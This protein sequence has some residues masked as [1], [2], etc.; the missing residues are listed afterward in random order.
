LGIS[1]QLAKEHIE[2][3]EKELKQG[4]IRRYR[5]K[6]PRFLFRHEKIENAA[7]ILQAGALLS[8][9]AAADETHDDIA[10]ATVITRR[11]EA[12]QFA[13]LYF[14]P[15]NPTQFHIEGIRQDGDPFISQDHGAHAP[16]LVMLVFRAQSVLTQNETCFSDGNMQHNRTKY[17][18]S[19]DFFRAIH[20][21]DV[22]HDDRFDLNDRDRIVRSRCA[23]VLA[24]SPLSLSNH[25]VAVLC[26]SEAER[27]TL[28]HLAPKL[29]DSVKQKIRTYS[30]V[31]VF[32]NEYSFVKDVDM[33][34]N[35]V[36]FTLNPRKD[37]KDV[38]LSIKIERKN[39]RIAIYSAADK[40]IS[41]SKK[42]HVKQPLSEGVYEVTIHVDGHLAYCAESTLSDLPF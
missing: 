21:Q 23:E 14:R 11:T 12:H 2:N 15:R 4:T 32:F 16:V 6:W 3:W 41:P 24:Q 28:L 38:S 17:E 37:E 26:R 10:P 36:S 35:G 40:L 7:T 13:R 5:S 18:K 27:R 22:F 9:N 31:G 30:E 42:W 29:S 34:S 33:N 8:R 20:F 1:A 39:D 25:L 19:E